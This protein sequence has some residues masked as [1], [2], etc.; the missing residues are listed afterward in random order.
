MNQG[1]ETIETDVPK[2]LDRLPWSRWHWLVVF[3]LGFVWILDGLEVTIVGSIGPTLQKASIHLSSFQVGLIGAFYVAGAVAGALL[4]GHLTDRWGRKKLFMITLALYLVAT[5]AT[6][7]SWNAISFF[8]FRFLAGA[9]IGGEYS[10]INSA[11][12]EL[13]P[14]RVRGWVDL[15]INGSWWLG[16]AAGALLSIPLLDPKLFRIDLGWRLAFG[17]GAILGIG[18]L[19]TRR[20][21]PE[22][23][24]WLMIKGRKEEAEQIVADIERQVTEQTGEQLDEPD[25]TIE[26]EPR[27][28]TGFSTIARTLFSRYRGRTVLG[29]TMMS[30]QAFAY[31]AVFFTYGL[32]LVNLMHAK[33]N[34]VGYYIVPFALGNFAGPILLGPLFDRVGRRIMLTLTHGAAGG[35]LAVTAV[36][37]ERHQLS[38]ISLTV[39]W[40]VVFFFASAA[41]SAAYLTVSEVFPLEIRAMAIAFFY[42]VGTGLGGILGPALFGKLIAS[43]SFLEVA[44]GFWIAAVWLIVAAVVAWFLAVDAE[45]KPLEEIAE[46]LSA[47]GGGEDGAADEPTQRERR[48]IAGYPVRAG[49]HWSPRYSFHGADDPLEGQ[50][51]AIE[52]AASESDRPLPERELLA[53]TN[54]RHWGPGVARRALRRAVQEGRIARDGSGYV[55][56]KSRV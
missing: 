51:A 35:V 44:V 53:R 36:L 22:S 33:S 31:N 5:V 9:G 6:A 25:G 15:A 30:A 45:Q 12:D 32:V 2:R 46:P 26:I 48:E 1:V 7:F 29:L 4:F 16:T 55:S 54:A 10:A 47:K 43:K 50:M 8:A 24:R 56:T 52:R 39:L 42:A 28:S 27:E 23:P 38:A 17:L 20:M 14:A 49:A 3:A 18:V 37:F 40:C 41:A 11:I 34:H 19:L 13:I 21:L